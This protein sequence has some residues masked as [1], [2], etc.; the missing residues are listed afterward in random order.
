M[1]PV[2]D[3]ASLGGGVIA[4]DSILSIQLVSCPSWEGRR[5]R[6]VFVKSVSQTEV[7]GILT[8]VCSLS[9]TCREVRL[10]VR[11]DLR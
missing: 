1:G 4:E 7:R 10:I 3:R 8:C 2:V 6:L 9:T 11:G 5:M